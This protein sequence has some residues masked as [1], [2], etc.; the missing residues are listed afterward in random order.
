M[1][2]SSES[3]PRPPSIRDVLARGHF[4]MVTFAVI[5][6]ATSL[7][8]TGAILLRTFNYN[9]LELTVRTVSYAVEPAM[10]FADGDEVRDAIRSV[11]NASRARRIE[12]LDSAGRV[13]AVWRPNA[14]DETRLERA[15]NRAIWPTPV[16]G[17][18]AGP[19]RKLGTVKA[20]GSVSQ[21]FRYSVW[22][23]A[24]GLACLA[25]TIVAT[26]VLARRLHREVVAP[27][28]HIAEVARAVSQDRQFDRRLTVSGIAEVDRFAKDFNSLLGELQGWQQTMLTEQR[29]L[30]HQ[31]EHDP[32][33]GLGN[34]AAFER[35]FKLAIAQAGPANRTLGLFFLDMDGFK[36]VNDQLGHGAGDAVLVEAAQRLSR[37]VRAPDRAFRL[38]GDEFA[39]LML[40]TLPD[41][42][43]AAVIERIRRAFEPPMVLPEGEEVGVAVSIGVACYPYEAADG[44][45]LR[46][47]ADQRMYNDK[48]K[49]KTGE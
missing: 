7:T 19:E 6:A 45:T 34:R 39:L 33:T 16:E 1:L 37:S 30:A 38:G 28:E 8:V 47:L 3:A 42:G 20:Y 24:I 10:F 22:G 21:A 18:I 48:R 43:A 12:V 15:L 46:I 11:S 49:R 26:R 25:I 2:M 4:R 31:A 27:L 14:D 32:L 17:P 41:C 23:F 40:S 29:A 35:E 36:D 5:L 13:V 44:Q 9:N